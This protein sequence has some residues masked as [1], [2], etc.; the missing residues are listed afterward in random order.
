MK[1]P[2]HYPEPQ[3]FAAA[4]A[5]PFGSETCNRITEPFGIGWSDA[6]KLDRYLEIYNIDSAVLGFGLTL[7]DRGMVWEDGP[8][9]S[10]TF[11]LTNC[12]FW[13]HETGQGTYGGPLWQ[14]LRFSDTIA[15]AVGKLGAPTRVGR[16]DIHH[17]ELPEFKLTIHWTSGNRIRVISYWM[18]E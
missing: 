2:T 3:D 7:K 8:T 15:E 6:I 4:I 9:N 18:K 14:G 12:A 13:G 11:L 17:W 16:L 1:A 10:G 5:Q